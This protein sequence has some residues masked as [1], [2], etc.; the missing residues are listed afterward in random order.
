[1]DETRVNLNPDEKLVSMTSSGTSVQME[2]LYT[3]H[4]SRAKLA[5]I[6]VRF[7][8]GSIWQAK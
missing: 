1:M 3:C 7:D 6:E 4:Q 5:V 2:E 8:D